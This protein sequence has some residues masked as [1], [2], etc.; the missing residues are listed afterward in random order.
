MYI[1]IY[2]YISPPGLGGDTFANILPGGDV[3]QLWAKTQPKAGKRPFVRIIQYFVSKI[4]KHKWRL[5]AFRGHRMLANIPFQKHIF[6]SF[7]GHQFWPPRTSP[8]S[9]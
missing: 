6:Y 7:G 4:Q 3:C 1:C 9:F 8:D 5:P 2:I